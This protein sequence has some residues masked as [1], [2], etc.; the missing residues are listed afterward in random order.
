MNE[1]SHATEMPP[2]PMSAERIAAEGLKALQSNRPTH[3]AEGRDAHAYG[4]LILNRVI[5]DA[6]VVGFSLKCAVVTV[7]SMDVRE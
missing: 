4:L 3:I 2:A 5:R 1:H 6:S 7:D